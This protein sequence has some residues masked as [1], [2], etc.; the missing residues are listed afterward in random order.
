[1]EWADEVMVEAAVETAALVVNINVK[2]ER[3]KQD[4]RK[5]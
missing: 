5:R 4:A 1:L 2:R 3:Y